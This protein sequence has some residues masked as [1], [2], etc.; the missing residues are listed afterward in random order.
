MPSTPTPPG[1]DP[2]APPAPELLPG[3]HSHH[4]LIEEQRSPQ[5]RGICDCGAERL[6]SNGWDEHRD[7]R[8]TWGGRRPQPTR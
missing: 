5:S 2:L 1:P 6:F 8:D 4:W 7:G 3:G